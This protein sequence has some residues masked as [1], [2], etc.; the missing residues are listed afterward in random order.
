M[1]VC[2]FLTSLISLFL[3]VCDEIR[4]CFK[5][6]EGWLAP[7]P[8]SEEFHF[9]LYDVYTK[10]KEVN[11]KKPNVPA[12]DDLV[13]FLS[14]ICKPHEECS[15]H[16]TLFVVG[17]PG[18]GKTTFRRKLVFGLARRR[19]SEDCIKRFDTMPIL[20]CCDMKSDLWETIYDQ[21]LPQEVR[22][23]LRDTFADFVCH[24]H[25]R[26]LLVH[27]G[28]D[29]VPSD[30]LPTLLEIVKGRVLPEYGLLAMAR[31]KPGMEEAT[32]HFETPLEIKEF[33]DEDAK[34]INCKFATG[35]WAQ[36]PLSNLRGDENLKNICP[37]NKTEL[38]MDIIRCVERGLPE[39][40]KDLIQEVNKTLLKHLGKITL[41][42]LR[43][44]SLDFEQSEIGSF[45][46]HSF[47]SFK[48]EGSEQW[49]HECYSSLHRSFQEW[50]AARYLCELLQKEISPESLFT[51][52]YAQ[53]LNEVLPS[54]CGLLAPWYE[55]TAA[56]IKSITTQVNVKT[57]EAQP[58]D[59]SCKLLVSMQKPPNKDDQDAMGF[60]FVARE[61][62]NECCIDLAREFGS[63][64][65]L[66][67]LSL[68]DQ[69]LS[70][71]NV[72]VLSNSLKWN[73]TVTELNLSG[74]NIGDAGASGLADLL[75]SNK[76]L[77]KL[78]LSQNA[79]GEAGALQLAAGLKQ[80]NTPLTVLDLADNNIGDVG[81]TCL[82][83][84]LTTNKTLREFNLSHN[85]IG[86][87]GA[88][89]LFDALKVNTILTLFNLSHNNI[90]DGGATYFSVPLTI[91]TT[92]TLFSLSHN[93]I[94]DAG[95][96]C[97]ADALTTNKTLAE[98]NLSHNNIGD[99]GATCLSEALKVNTTLTLFNLSHNKIGDGGATSLADA[100]TVNRF[101][102]QLN[103][104]GN[105][106]VGESALEPLSNLVPAGRVI[107]PSRN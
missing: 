51:C 78:K 29:E 40:S 12:T 77:T 49:W 59:A 71:A 39:M 30:K 26:L 56:L 31:H 82:A 69:K 102:S 35:D 5:L 21:R 67:S 27:D 50:L 36:K 10:L 6:C 64:L 100:L 32:K 25:T 58:S 7:F 14:A 55:E 87:V 38:Y 85:S 74:N 90:G 48:P 96:T 103:L 42:G 19:Q 92:L 89:C 23:E 3:D 88:T 107:L 33:T 62:I 9:H 1:I 53:Q 63:S 44:D 41:N 101:M 97:L 37:E 13:N 4:Q 93:D 83:D 2:I 105:N 8:W 47:S 94:G 95:A 28:L 22:R 75:K 81:A 57:T 52:R 46:D 79:I 60:V 70:V 98:F 15:Q 65:E 84:G 61:C 34:Q 80:G 72:H 91:N 99:V 76:I 18:M 16:I 104:Y 106:D 54:T 66:H 24:N 68:Q 11:R 86:D 43:K 17:E 73:T 20:R 45:T